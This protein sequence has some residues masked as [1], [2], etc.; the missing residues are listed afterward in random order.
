MLMA[1]DEGWDVDQL[2]NLLLYLLAQLSLHNT[3][4]Y[5]TLIRTAVNCLS[6]HW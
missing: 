3:D 1:V 6:H 4:L 5:N 2:L